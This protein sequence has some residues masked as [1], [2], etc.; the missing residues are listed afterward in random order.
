V[1]NELKIDEGKRNPDALL[2][3]IVGFGNAIDFEQR[4]PTANIDSIGQAIGRLKIDETGVE[5]TFQAIQAVIAE[6]GRFITKERRLLIVLVTDESGDD[7]D[8]MEEARQL[9]LG[10]GV[11]IYVIGRQSMFGK[12]SVVLPYKD[13]V[14][15][16]MY[17]PS[18]RRGPESA[19]LEA[20]QWDG[21][22]PR[23]D[24]Q[25]SGFAPYELARMTEDTGGVY[26]LLPSEEYLRATQREKAYSMSTLKEYVPDYQSRISYLDRRMKSPVRSMIFEIVKDSQKIPT[27]IDF[28]IEAPGFLEAADMAAG[29]A[30]AKLATLLAIEQRLRDPKMLNLRDREPEKRWQASFDLTLA[31]VVAYQVKTYEYIACLAELVQK[32][33]SGKPPQPSK[34]P[35]KDLVVNWRL[36]HSKEPKAPKGQTEKK[37]AEALALMKKV[38]ERHPNTP[39]A[40]LAQDEINRGF[41]VGWGEHSTTSQYA[42]RMKLVPKY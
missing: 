21:L 12:D 35:T 41:S 6:Y 38:I 15:G 32:Y 26:F 33:Q 13:P 20:F 42:E 28:P 10:R 16:D 22:H 17:Y 9:A 39:W 36:G 4:K 27:R 8:Y 5:K 29:E 37:Y 34:M 23:W 2:H 14:T 19:D 24:E 11:P 30:K 25:P 18:I 40:D 31:Q 3:S 1:A 7:G